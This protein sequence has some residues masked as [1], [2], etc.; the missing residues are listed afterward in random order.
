MYLVYGHLHAYGLLLE[1]P[2]RSDVSLCHG[3]RAFASLPFLC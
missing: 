3:D 1:N 2:Y